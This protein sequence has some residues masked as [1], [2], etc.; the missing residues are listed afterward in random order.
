MASTSKTRPLSTPTKTLNKILDDNDDDLD[1]SSD[2]S[3]SIDGDDIV[4]ATDED[5]G[6]DEYGLANDRVKDETNDEEDDDGDSDEEEDDGDTDS[7]DRLP[8][9]KS[10][11]AKTTGRKKTDMPPVALP[12]EVYTSPS[13]DEWS[14]DEPPQAGLVLEM[15]CDKLQGHT[16]WEMSSARLTF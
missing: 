8:P 15:Y 1:F 13:G 4:V 10:K 3:E 9:K 5:E 2:D 7:E 6:M 16:I 14:T 11:T 12:P